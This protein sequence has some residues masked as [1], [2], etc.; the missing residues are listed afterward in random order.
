MATGL[1]RHERKGPRRKRVSGTIASYPDPLDVSELRVEDAERMGFEVYPAIMH[2][3]LQRPRSWSAARRARWNRR[4]AGAGDTETFWED[5][6]DW[7]TDNAPDICP[8][9]GELLLLQGADTHANTRIL[10]VEVLPVN[11]RVETV[12]VACDRVRGLAFPRCGL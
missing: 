4:K 11:G 3:R 2:L 8:Q 12:V 7:T 9:E 1:A 5:N 10:R 6:L